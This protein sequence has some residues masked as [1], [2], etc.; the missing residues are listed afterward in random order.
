MSDNN[1][2]SNLS[3][4]GNSYH[5]RANKQSLD[6]GNPQL[7]TNNS[8]LFEPRTLKQNFLKQRRKESV[9]LVILN[10]IYT[11]SYI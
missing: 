3:K 1:I 11:Y 8:P 5:L 10:D 9:I 4:K 6:K 7:N 2:V